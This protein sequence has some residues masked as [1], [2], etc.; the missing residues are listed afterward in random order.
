[1]LDPIGSKTPCNLSVKLTAFERAVEV[2]KKLSVVTDHGA[3]FIALRQ[4]Q[5]ESLK[6]LRAI[7]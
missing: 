3:N 1:M 5:G 7:Y 2:A 6:D 4:R